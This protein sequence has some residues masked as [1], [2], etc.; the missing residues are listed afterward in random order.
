MRDGVLNIIS[1]VV[2]LAVA[3][4]V[5][6]CVGTSDGSLTDKVTMFSAIGAMVFAGVIFFTIF[7]FEMLIITNITADID[8]EKIIK[9]R[10][11]RIKSN[12]LD[13]NKENKK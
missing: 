8:A 3:A 12:V 7:F 9:E 1:V 10:E 5:V 6:I 11:E 4:T 2:A 13:L